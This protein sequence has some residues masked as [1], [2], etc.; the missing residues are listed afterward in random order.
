VPSAAGPPAQL[1]LTPP[2]T[3]FRVGGGPYTVPVSMTNASRV[4]NVTITITFN[5]AAVRVRSVQEGSFLRQGGVNA[6]FTQQVD[7]AAG[8]IDIAVSRNGDNTGAS[9]AGLV[10]AILFDAVAAGPANLSATATAAAPGG[11]AIPVT[12]PPVAVT[13]R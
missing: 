10:A 6:T 4:S 13:V 5:P 7:A 12:V 11:A 9:G 1:L 3:E 8:R 2:G